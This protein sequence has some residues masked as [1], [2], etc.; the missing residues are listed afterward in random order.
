RSRTIEPR[1]GPS[2]VSGRNPGMVRGAHG[3]RWA[4]YLGTAAMLILA[5][6]FPVG[7]MLFNPT[8]MF[9]RGWAQ[10]VGTGIYL[11]AVLSLRRER[12]RVRRD[13]PAFDDAP[14]LLK[15]VNAAMARGTSR[16]GSTTPRTVADDDRRVLTRR[17]R[18]LVNYL[19]ESR[20]PSV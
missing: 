3:S 15:R 8:L 16:D 13:E 7:L 20:S 4:E 17:V 11:W 6:L 1:L 2:R 5:L 12:I 10:Y 18:Q 14:G 19:K 9:E